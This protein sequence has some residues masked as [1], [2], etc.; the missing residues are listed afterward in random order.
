MGQLRLIDKRK[1]YLCETKTCYQVLNGDE[2]YNRTDF[3]NPQMLSS[4]KELETK[5]SFIKSV[6]NCFQITEDKII[7]LKSSEIPRIDGECCECRG[8]KSFQK[9]ESED[10]GDRKVCHRCL[11]KKFGEEWIKKNWDKGHQED[12]FEEMAREDEG[13]VLI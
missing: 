3:E 5:E 11:L 13:R 10:Y 1:I 7:W 8:T 4:G 12:F 6:I 2:C 9:W